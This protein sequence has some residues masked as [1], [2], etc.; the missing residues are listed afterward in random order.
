MHLFEI[1][2]DENDRTLLLVEDVQR[3]LLTTADS[4][5]DYYTALKLRGM[6]QSLQDIEPIN[7]W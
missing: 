5:P 3:W 2:V 4:E 6:A 1:G 7:A